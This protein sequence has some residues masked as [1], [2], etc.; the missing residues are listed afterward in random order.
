MAAINGVPASVSASNKSAAEDH[1]QHPL[2]HPD[3]DHSYLEAATGVERG[4]AHARTHSHSEI[5][6]ARPWWTFCN[7]AIHIIWGLYPVAARWLQT[8]PDEPLP[9]FRLTFYINAIACLAL[10]LFVTAPQNAARSYAALRYGRNR[11]KQQPAVG[12]FDSQAPPLRQR[13]CDVAVFAIC[14]GILAAC[15]VIASRFTS[16]YRVQL[17]FTTSP[18]WTALIATVALREAP[19]KLLWPSFGGTLAGSA[20]VVGGAL[21]SAPQTLTW[22][23]L[24][25][26]MLALAATLALSVYFVYVSKTSDWLPE[27]AILYINYCSVFSFAPLISALFERGRWSGIFSFGVPDWLALL[28]AGA[29]VY[30]FGKY[31]QQVVIRNIGA[32]QYALFISVRLVA[33]VVGS[34][35][36]LDEA[37][38]WLQILGCVIVCSSVSCYVLASGRLK[39]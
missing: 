4:A 23:D 28:Y 14:L 10:F 11:Q 37:L 3:D 31:T 25:G 16:A 9:P 39:L 18:L 27:S 32:T 12:R 36:V 8:R 26:L 29:G 5:N 21:H 38:D 1:E 33:A 22:R 30:A 2:R 34:A 17:I 13:A 24:L 19:P 15:A 7:V 35:L 20:L 6:A